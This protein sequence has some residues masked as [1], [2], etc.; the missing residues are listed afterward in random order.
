[1]LRNNLLSVLFL[2]KHRNFAVTISSLHMDITLNGTTLFST[3]VSE[4]NTAHLSGTTLP[5]PLS[6]TECAACASTLPL[7][8]SLWHCRFAHVNADRVR[9]LVSKQLVSGLILESTMRLHSDA[10]CEPCL[11]GKMHA[12]PFPSS[13][14][15]AHA[16][17]VLVHSD[18]KGPMLKQTH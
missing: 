16:R 5:A 14:L 13:T 11:A 8:K 7:D 18:L 1:M 3:P 17:G 2:T 12:N 15:R 6:S 9:K 4:Q 10:L